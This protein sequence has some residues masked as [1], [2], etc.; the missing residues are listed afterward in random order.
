MVGYYW[1]SP[2]KKVSINYCVVDESRLRDHRWWETSKTHRLPR[3]KDFAK[4]FFTSKCFDFKPFL[5]MHDH[6][7]SSSQNCRGHIFLAKLVKK[8][9]H[10]S[11]FTMTFMIQEKLN[12]SAAAGKSQRPRPPMLS[13]RPVAFYGDMRY[14]RSITN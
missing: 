10:N 14:L 11:N 9:M 8:N 13:H 4:L 12:S 7:T 6:G 2:S 1:F 3:I 5:T